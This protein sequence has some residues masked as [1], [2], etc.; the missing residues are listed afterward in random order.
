MDN[1][2][3]TLT[4]PLIGQ[5]A[6]MATIGWLAGI[7]LNEA[8]IRGYHNPPEGEFLF[9]MAIVCVGL[10]FAVAFVFGHT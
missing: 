2:I 1:A 6:V 4:L 7:L 10:G 3:L 9:A 8:G 5:F